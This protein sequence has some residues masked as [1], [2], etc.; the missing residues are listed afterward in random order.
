[1][2]QQSFANAVSGRSGHQRFAKRSRSVVTNG[3]NIPANQNVFGSIARVTAMIGQWSDE[4]HMLTETSHKTVQSRSL[5]AS[6]AG[7]L[8]RLLVRPRNHTLLL[9]ANGRT[10]LIANQLKRAG[11]SVSLI[12]LDDGAGALADGQIEAAL[13]AAKAEN[14]ICVLAV[15]SSTAL[16]QRLCQVATD[17]F[18]VP[19]AIARMSWREGL[20]GWVRIGALK[21]ERIGWPEAVRIVLDGV[22]PCGSFQ[23]VALAD[24]HESVAEIE[25]VSPVFAGRTAQALPL[26]ELELVAI[27]RGDELFDRPESAER[28][29]K[30]GDY[31]ILMGSDERIKKFRECVASV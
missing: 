3:R 14:S 20:T 13:K 11:R 17:R 25:L 12:D 24:D 22:T 21:S 31:L 16:N 15:T 23:R 1:M 30:T 6:V 29:L 4:S 19:H 8:G 18:G 5:T 10:R 27:R 26:H 9:G 7:L 28:E 2:R